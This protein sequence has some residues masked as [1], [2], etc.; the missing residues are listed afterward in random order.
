MLNQDISRH[1]GLHYVGCSLWFMLWLVIPNNGTLKYSDVRHARHMPGITIGCSGVRQ[2]YAP[3]HFLHALV[4]A[5]LQPPGCNSL[6]CR[7]PPTPLTEASSSSHAPLSAMPCI[8][9]QYHHRTLVMN[10]PRPALCK[11]GPL[12]LK[13]GYSVTG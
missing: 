1:S 7:M 10:M 12:A 13:P 5:S 8:C 6:P 9:R 2:G 3:H 4:S 11:S